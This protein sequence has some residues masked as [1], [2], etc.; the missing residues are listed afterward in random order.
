MRTRASQEGVPLSQELGALAL[1]RLSILFFCLPINDI[2]PG[3]CR[4]SAN[5]SVHPQS[6]KGV[7]NSLKTV[8][9]VR[10][11]AP[12][13]AFGNLTLEHVDHASLF[14]PLINKFSQ[15]AQKFSLESGEKFFRYGFDGFELMMKFRG[16][17][18][19]DFIK[20]C[21]MADPD[22]WSLESDKTGG[23]IVSATFHTHAENRDESASNACYRAFDALGLGSAR[24]VVS[25]GEVDF[26]FN[27]DQISP[28]MR[29]FPSLKPENRHYL[30]EIRRRYQP[31][32]NNNSSGQVCR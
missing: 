30:D 20:Y 9:Q 15:I 13:L 32:F 10:I 14:N 26:V 22:D 11:T 21:C 12:M 23:K 2:A 19:S 4:L 8:S 25:D 16:K 6:R 31:I 18:R 17:S 24:K 29:T 3:D 27:P 1:E 5:D 28:I 7:K